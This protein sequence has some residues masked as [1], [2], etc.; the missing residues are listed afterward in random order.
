M[1]QDL[2]TEFRQ[3][4]K[5]QK[6]RQELSKSVAQERMVTILW[7]PGTQFRCV[8]VHISNWSLLFYEKDGSKN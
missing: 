2:G 6:F 4:R 8:P 7:G 5:D 1:I 3:P